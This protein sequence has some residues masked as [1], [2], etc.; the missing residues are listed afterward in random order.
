MVYTINT[1]DEVLAF[2]QR[3]MEMVETNVIS[4]LLVDPKLAAGHD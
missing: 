3:G 1:A 2:G 4:R